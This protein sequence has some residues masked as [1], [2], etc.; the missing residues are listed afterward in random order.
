[1][2]INLGSSQQIA[3]VLYEQLGM[4][5]RRRTKGGK[6]STDET[7]VA[8]LAKQYPVVRKIQNWKQ[9]RKLLGTYLEVYEREYTY[10]PDGRAH[11]GWLQH[12]VPG[13]RFSASE[14]PVQQTPKKYNFKLADGSLEFKLNF[15][16]AICAPP[17]WYYLGFDYSQQEL[18]VL[19]GEAGETALMDAFARGDDVHKLTASL[20]LGKPVEEITY[21]ER[22]VGKTMN[23]ALGYQ[24]GVDGL[25]DRLGIS[26]DEAQRLFD[27]YFSVYSKIKGYMD[28]VVAASKAQGYVMTRFG[29]KV[30]IWEYLSDKRNVYAEGERLA[31]NAPIQ[32][33]G[34]GDYTKIAMVRSH[35][36]I[37]GAHLQDDVRLV[38]N[39]H[40]AL[41]YYV[42]DNIPPAQVIRI[43]QPAV[44]FPVE[45][46]P[47][48]VAEWHA[49]RRWGS[50]QELEVLADGSVRVKRDEAP[51]GPGPVPVVAQAPDI[52]PPAAA[53]A[54]L[55]QE[56]E[57]P[58]EL[59]VHRAGGDGSA[60]TGSVGVHPAS[61]TPAR[62]IVSVTAIPDAETFQRFLNL[63]AE[64]GPELYPTVL[65]T[66]DGD[67]EIGVT[68]LTPEWSS[69]VSLVLGGAK[70]T[71]DAT[72]ADM[73]GLAAGLAL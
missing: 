68:T 16:E 55:A 70:V 39:M 58:A 14:P 57:H 1:V 43:L 59:V 18:R 19:A 6:M 5:T 72:T 61:G 15:R 34:T 28:Q 21:D 45:G 40:D 17:G 29:R 53:P 48:I 9:L 10:A 47:P 54:V 13:G 52:E 67:V 38:L 65:R 26:K 2:K 4:H 30:V 44:V 71:W 36:A 37:K 62:V 3:H 73:S 69:Q 32:G 20:M 24:M 11:P 12:G 64:C 27:L 41:G 23:F 8:G 35:A 42:R 25:A 7:A 50:V 49:G 31:G 51:A 22:Q 46:W 60:D 56:Q 66:P 63:A 33:A